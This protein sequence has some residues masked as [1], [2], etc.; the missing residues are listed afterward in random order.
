MA[1]LRTRAVIF[2]F[3]VVACGPL[4]AQHSAKAAAPSVASVFEAKCVRCHGAEQ[5]SGLDLRTRAGLVKGGSRGSAIRP[6]NAAASLLFKAVSS[7]TGLKMPPGRAL[8]AGEVAAIRSWINAGASATALPKKWDERPWSFRPPA[9]PSV[10][11]V[12][13]SK[14]VRNPIDSF[15]LAKL[16]PAGLKPNPEA[17]RR[18]LIRRLS[19]DLIGL[20]P[21]PAE[22]E[23]FVADKSPRAYENLVN[24]LLSSPNYGEKWARHW[25]DL[26][27]YAESEG[28]KADEA[29]PNAWRYR[30]YVISSLNADKPYDRFVR[31]QIAGDELFPDDPAALIATGFC[32][33][34]AD[35][36]NARNIMQR[37]QEIL[38]DI[39]DTTASVVLGLTVGCARCH[40]HKYDPIKQTDYYRLQAYFAAVNPLT[41]VPAMTAAEREARAAQ[42]KLWTSAT[43]PTTAAISDMEAPMRAKIGKDKLRKFPDEVRA[44]VETPSARRSPLQAILAHKVAPQLEANATEMKAAMTPEQRKLRD[45][46]ESDMAA[47]KAVALSDEPRGLGIRDVGP[48]APSTFSLAVGVYDARMQEVRPGLIRAIGQPNPEITPVLAPSDDGSTVRPVSTGRRSALARWLTS[49]Q[50]PLTARVMVNRLWQQHFGRGLVATASD[51]GSQ[52]DE[53]SHPELLDWLS[54]EFMRSNWSLKQMHRV[55]VTSSAYRQSSAGNRE[56]LRIDPNNRLVWR[57]A[58]RRLDAE[59][60]RDGILSISGELNTKLGGP[61]VMPDL[62]AGVTTV[63]YWKP[64]VEAAERNRRSVYI[65]VKRNLRYPMLEVFDLPDTHEPCALRQPTITAPQA[66]ALFNNDLVHRSAASLAKR[67]E[68]DAQKSDASRIDVAYRIVLGRPA[69][70]QEIAM[71]VR[72]LAVGEPQQALL[73]LCHVLINSNEFVTVE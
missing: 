1:N 6:N 39:T 16:K 31:E 65:F 23:A 53:P 67:V 43:A 45:K 47:H 8:D 59:A 52:G 22:T 41:D 48:E 14:W 30:D 34:W 17:N 71:G 68:Q 70:P 26:A 35:E 62:P 10:P 4:H 57:Y 46:L 27:R 54:M 33:N 42:A 44:A 36:S 11:A 32:R 60:I 72:F 25:L 2:T 29:R 19:F 40:D 56:A 12:A 21:T 49:P 7:K 73:D 18:T 64:T 37:R 5:R 58:R 50:N 55:M 51:F 38:N 3:A 28:F 69:A 61:S 15:V 13:N 9:R 24:R 66:L 63:G 20:P